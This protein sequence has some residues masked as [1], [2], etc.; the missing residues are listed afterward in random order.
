MSC[1]VHEWNKNLYLTLMTN[2]SGVIKWYVDAL[3][4]I[5]HDWHNP[6]ITTITFEGSIATSLSLKQKVNAKSSPKLRL[7]K[8]I[9]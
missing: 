7:L 5:H 8:L 3:Y 4:A 6:T 1:K 9:K 2:D